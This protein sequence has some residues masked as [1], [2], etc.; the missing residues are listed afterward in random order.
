M[1]AVLFAGGVG[2]RLWP[3]S[4]RNT[5]KQFTPIL[6]TKSSLQL[7]VEHLLPIIPLENIFISTNERY[8]ELLT[9]QV[10]ELP[11]DNFILEPVRRDVAAAV[12]YAFLKL[13]QKGLSG[14]IL[15]QWSDTYVRH[16]DR[17]RAAIDVGQE[18]IKD[19][20]QR[21][22]FLGETP[23]FVSENLGY[24]EHGQ[25]VG[26]V[27]DMPFY[28]FR[29][30]VYRPHTERCAQMIRAGNYV[31][32]SGFYVTTIEFIADQYRKFTP[33]IT[34]IID[35]ILKD[36]GTDQEYPSLHQLYPTIPTMH[37]DESFLMR[38][39]P[40]QALLLKVNLGWSDP[41]S[42]YS[43]KEALQSSRDSNVTQGEVVSV[44]TRDSLIINEE[45]GKTISVMGL[46]GLMIVNTPDA[47]L[48]I[49]KD[50]VRHIKLLLDELE[51][52]GKNEI[53]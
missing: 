39:Q 29:S 33:Q 9:Q 36:E 37:F 50:S 24:I 17:L 3:I 16:D 42:L 10:P 12:A 48:V 51:R 20:P 2:Q 26:R 11:K 1:Y 8:G 38:L 40:D 27:W 18:L 14:P 6:G 53:L 35:E 5:P 7:A 46:Q 22:V 32:N 23:R 45:E 49:A 47:L 31:W 21:L 28:E 44:D 43:L 15:F 13:Q 4:R 52:Q 34:Q 30:M 25:E 41:G 19:N